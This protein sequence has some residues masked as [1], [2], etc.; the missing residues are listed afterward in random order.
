M[1]IVRELRE[2]LREQLATSFEGQETI[3]KVTTTFFHQFQNESMNTQRKKTSF[4]YMGH[5]GRDRIVPKTFP[6]TRFTRK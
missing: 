6:D 4:V 1:F 5:W 2:Q 3:L